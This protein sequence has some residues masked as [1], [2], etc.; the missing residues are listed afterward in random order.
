IKAEVDEQAEEDGDEEPRGAPPNPTIEALNILLA[1][2][3]NWARA[4]SEGRQTIGGQSGRTIQLIKSRLPPD[5]RFV[6]IGAKI[7]LAMHL[8]TLI[9]APRRFVLG[10]P[11]LYARF[12]REA[13]RSGRHFVLGTATVEFFNGNRISPDELDVLILIML[14]NTRRIIG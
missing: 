7:A 12:R 10:I 3:R 9:Q 8:R 11:A 5:A 2:L 13:L 4:V 1:A 6:S 14:R